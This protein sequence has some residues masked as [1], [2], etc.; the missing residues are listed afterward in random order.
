MIKEHKEKLKHLGLVTILLII[1]MIFWRNHSVLTQLD[2]DKSLS[3]SSGNEL[4][5]Y[6]I[7]DAY[8]GDDEK[9]FFKVS[10][11]VER[12]KKFYNS[13]VT[14]EEITFIEMGF[15]PISIE[16]F[17]G[18]AKFEYGYESGHN[19]ENYRTE[20]REFTSVKALHYNQQLIDSF[21]L[22]LEFG[23]MPLEE[24]FNLTQNEPISV[25]LGSEY[26]GTYDIGDTFMVDNVGLFSKC[27]VIGILSENQYVLNQGHEVDLNRSV[28]MPSLNIEESPENQWERNLQMR[29]YL[30]KV[31][32]II[33]C[34]ESSVTESYKL[35]DELAKDAKLKPYGKIG[36]F[37]VNE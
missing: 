19:G 5:R 17:E 26:K 23:E 9:V 20:N 35:I 29:I 8:T 14:N 15:Q 28:L 7:F 2:Q 30:Q 3:R 32:G 24:N 13:L 31:N 12:L 33:E 21:E 16:N 27:K 22:E 1:A 18:E 6:H 37:V 10:D 34:E 25:I 4:V 11:N 36:P